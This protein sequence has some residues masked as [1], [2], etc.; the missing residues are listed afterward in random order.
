[1][2]RT[3]QEAVRTTDPQI[4]D[5][6]IDLGVLAQGQRLPTMNFDNIVIT[7]PAHP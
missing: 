1:M 3:G 6:N 2:V 7:T 4:R 5:G